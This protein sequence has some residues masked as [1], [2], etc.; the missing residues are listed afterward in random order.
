MFNDAAAGKA[1][2]LVS[3]NPFAGLGIAKTKG[4]KHRQPPDEQAIWRMLAK[5]REL[6]PPSFASAGLV[7]S[8]RPAAAAM[9]GLVESF[10]PS[11]AGLADAIRPSFPSAAIGGSYEPVSADAL[12]QA[13]QLAHRVFSWA[14]DVD[15]RTLLL[16]SGMV[17]V[18]LAAAVE[19]YDRAGFR[20]A[21][22]PLLWVLLYVL[23]F[24]NSAEH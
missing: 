14:R 8:V 18:A 9:A 21:V 5:A 11:L 4:N 2:R 24:A 1:G 3:I 16:K 17:I 22:I 23:D 12:Q 19:A 6:T 15:H 20:G 13:R 7:G 10:R